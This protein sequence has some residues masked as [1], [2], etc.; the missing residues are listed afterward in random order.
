METREKNRGIMEVVGEMSPEA[1]REF[2][3]KDVTQYLDFLQE[4]QSDCFNIVPLEEYEDRNRRLSK[5]LM[6]A[7]AEM[8]Q[9]TLRRYGT[10]DSEFIVDMPDSHIRKR[11]LVYGKLSRIVRFTDV[12]STAR[13]VVSDM[14]EVEAAEITYQSSLTDDLGVDSLD[15]L[16]LIMEAERSFGIRISDEE[17]VEILTFQDVVDIIMLKLQDFEI[18]EFGIDRLSEILGKEVN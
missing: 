11:V 3:P 6:H 15:F 17:M 13:E 8:I 18:E 4:R 9:M 16:E 14:L 1:A 10:A 2:V 12:E 7:R 5:E